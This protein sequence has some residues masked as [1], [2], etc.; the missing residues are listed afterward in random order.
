MTVTSGTCLTARR[1][2]GADLARMLAA[3]EVIGNA[4]E[5]AEA[6]LESAR[7]EAAML[8]ASA[9]QAIATERSEMERQIEDR[10]TR[11]LSQ[12]KAEVAA[13][14]L[15]ETADA[16]ARL[17]AR[18]DALAPWISELVLGTVARLVGTLDPDERWQRILEQAIPASRREWDLSLRCHSSSVLALQ[19]LIERDRAGLGRLKAVRCIV[20]DETLSPGDCILESA[21]GLIEIGIAAQIS[22]LRQALGLDM[23]DPSS[24]QLEPTADGAT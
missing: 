23:V 9:R 15:A 22:Q 18:F 17:T 4:R 5:E 21:D 2:A 24:S 3:S 12:T 8:Q 7:T 14:R 16:A 19:S 20:E 11:E 13:M 10:R 1:I 6:L